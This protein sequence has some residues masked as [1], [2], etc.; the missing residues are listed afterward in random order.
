MKPYSLTR[1]LITAVLLVELLSALAIT[2]I[3]MVYERHTQF[4][5][6]D[7]MLRGR[8]DS[9]LGAVQ[10][11]GDEQDNVMLDVAELSLPG[12]DIYEVR[13]AD[14][15]ILGRSHNWTGPGDN[16]LKVDRDG[17]LQFE[18]NGRRYR[19]IQMHGVRI[20]D[21]GDKGGGIPRHVTV[22]YGAPT[23][24][25]LEAVSDA[26]EFY[27]AASLLLLAVSGILMF[28][29][30]NRGLTPLR[31]LAA[32]AAVVSVDS[33]EFAPSE[34]ARG[35][36]ELAPLTGA[37]EIVLRGLKHSFTQQHQFVSDAAH[38]LK[39]AVA[40]A[41]SSLQ[42][43][44]MRH[45]TAA[46]YEAGLER[47]Q[48]DCERMEEIVAKMLALARVE[49]Q[50]LSTSFY[51]SNL[52]QSAR[53]AAEQLETVAQVNRQ[54]IS[55]SG[56]EAVDVDVAPEQLRLLCSNLMLNALQH[57]PQGSEVRAM[58]MA[59]SH[60]VELRVEDDGEGIEPGILPHV[61]DRFYRSDP[62]RSRKTGGTGLGLAICKA[63]VSRV[64]GTIEI[65]SESG[66]GTIVLVRFPAGQ[67]DGTV[68]REGF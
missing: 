63:I 65:T 51:S 13:R 64:R 16:P 14:G 40:V 4:H 39:T 9:V 22:L 30:L 29:L 67:V 10:E 62:S 34:R 20:V 59:D 6:F 26:V 42:L 45:R 46:E 38:E 28:W 31:E 33:W 52:F 49:S 27:A 8:A 23:E 7:I 66:R 19:A 37:L 17:F 32:A 2:G 44:T 35:I 18:V 54:R 50:D 11:A 47:C 12:R 56:A 3:A 15:R 57:S 5:A 48:T 25:A 55:V 41:K 1:R 36:K 24:H 60:N 58:V 21:P 68:S 61:F 53:I 43:L